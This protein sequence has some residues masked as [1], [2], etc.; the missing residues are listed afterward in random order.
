MQKIINMHNYSL[1]L[2]QLLTTA[3]NQYLI[4]QPKKKKKDDTRD[5]KKSKP[6]NR[7]ILDS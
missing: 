4:Q 3:V 2:N 1:H 7:A 5:K 6:Q